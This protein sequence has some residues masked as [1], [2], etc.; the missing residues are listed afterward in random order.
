[1]IFEVVLRTGVV[2]LRLVDR[3]SSVWVLRFRF[4][5]ELFLGIKDL[6]RPIEIRR[7][8]WKR[9]DLF[10]FF[11]TIFFFLEYRFLRLDRLIRRGRYVEYRFRRCESTLL[12]NLDFE[13][14]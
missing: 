12:E 6:E 4:G 9:L 1:M 2:L 7:F 10:V 11:E 5:L 14:L 13:D 8:P 3:S